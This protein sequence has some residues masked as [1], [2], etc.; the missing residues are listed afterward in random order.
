MDINEII[1]SLNS[2]VGSGTLGDVD[3][4]ALAA[5]ITDTQTLKESLASF[6]TLHDDM[7]TRIGRLNELIKART[8]DRKV[9]EE[10]DSVIH[11]ILAC[12]MQRLSL[13]SVTSDEGARAVLSSRAVIEA[14]DEA[15]LSGL[16]NTAEFK[17]L[18]AAL[19]PYIRIKLSVDKTALKSAIKTDAAMRNALASW[20]RTRDNYTLNIK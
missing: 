16:E 5:G 1:D 2:A 10:F 12:A 9:W 14:D 19:P 18:E 11:R 3:C 8:D 13:T 6:K 15:L 4:E 7:L 17:S 20:V